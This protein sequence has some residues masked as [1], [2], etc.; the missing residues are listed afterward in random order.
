MHAKLK[1]IVTVKTRE[2]NQEII[3]AIERLI[4]KYVNTPNMVP[5]DKV[6]ILKKIA[7]LARGL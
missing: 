2:F 5:G 4:R 7:Q 6:V 1:E 3:D